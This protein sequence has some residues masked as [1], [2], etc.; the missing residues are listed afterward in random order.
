MHRPRKKPS[1]DDQIA[2]ARRIGDVML[3][4][5]WLKGNCDIM[6]ETVTWKLIITEL[7]R[8]PAKDIVKYFAR[9]QR[10]GMTH[11]AVQLG[12][13]LLD[14]NTSGL[15]KPRKLKAKSINA[16]I[17][18]SLSNPGLMKK[19]ESQ[20]D[21]F[22][23][24]VAA[25]IVN[26]NRNKVYGKFNANCQHFID[27]ILEMGMESKP[28]WSDP[29]A[30]YLDGLRKD[31]DNGRPHYIENGKRVFFA[32]HAELDQYVKNNRGNLS[33]EQIKLFKAFDRG[34]L[35]RWASRDYNDPE[36]EPLHR[37]NIDPPGCS[38]FGPLTTC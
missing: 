15:C 7:P 6:K 17:D 30:A 24:A 4:A 36:C 31:A 23:V 29:I 34:Y 12:S 21:D 9:K 8:N 25:V 19:K 27:D 20:M 14:W 26:W 33:P 22:F 37:T 3:M 32:S 1:H 28:F 2:L 10:Y 16:A 11:A 18:L 35:I 38:V 5:G 13:T